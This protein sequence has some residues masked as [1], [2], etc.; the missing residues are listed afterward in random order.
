MNYM[1]IEEA[2]GAIEMTTS[3]LS[4]AIDYAE[5]KPGKYL[6]CRDDEEQ[7]VV[8]DTQPGVTYKI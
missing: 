6:V 5:S 2:S 3:D 8:W 4:E 7:S 1:V